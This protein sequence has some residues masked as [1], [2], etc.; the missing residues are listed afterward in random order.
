MKKNLF[1]VAIVLLTSLLYSCDYDLTDNYVHIDEPTETPVDIDLN[2][3]SNGESFIIHKESDIEF[4]L[5]AF[6][7]DINSAIFKMGAKEWKFNK[8]EE[9]IISIT[10]EEFPTGDYTLTCDLFIKAAVAALPTNTT[11]SFSPIVFPGRFLLT[12]I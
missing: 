10:E 4:A 6:G 9:G 11:R 12:I 5:T 3:I 7:K 2:M 1:L 8:E